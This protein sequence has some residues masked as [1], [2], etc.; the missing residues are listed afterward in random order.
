M[1]AHA[2]EYAGAVAGMQETY[3]PASQ[4][5]GSRYVGD[6]LVNVWANND[7]VLF[8]A[9]DGED[10]M[11]RI[12]EACPDDMY[13]ISCPDGHRRIAHADAIYPF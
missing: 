6:R 1:D 5:L 12:V 2:R 10:H 4:P 9:N 3:G 7:V 13:V 11:G 8:Q